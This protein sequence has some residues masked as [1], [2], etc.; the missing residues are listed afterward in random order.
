MHWAGSADGSDWTSPRHPL[1]FTRPKMVANMQINKNVG[2][3]GGSGCAKLY[4]LQVGI[5]MD[6]LGEDV[7]PRSED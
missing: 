6:Q 4:H 5:G 1:V 2:S 7:V 3:K